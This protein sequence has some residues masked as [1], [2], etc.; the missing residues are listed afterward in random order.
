MATVTDQWFFGDTLSASVTYNN[1]NGAVSSVSVTN[2][3]GAPVVGNVSISGKQ[4]IS[5]T[6]PVGTNSWNVPNGW[7]WGVDTPTF[8]AWWS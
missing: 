3:T 4:P 5:H 8:S 1:A 6:F 7:S 2:N